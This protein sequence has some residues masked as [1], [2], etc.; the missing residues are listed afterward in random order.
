MSS[1]MPP[2]KLSARREPLAGRHTAR[3]AAPETIEKIGG[4]AWTRTRNQT[5]MSADDM[6]SDVENTDEFGS[7][8]RDF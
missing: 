3:P 1:V 5:V 2:F 6:S 7:F 4:P 8:D